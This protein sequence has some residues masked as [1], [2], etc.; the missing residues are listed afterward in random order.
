M[1]DETIDSLVLAARFDDQGLDAQARG[2][3]N[4]VANAV[5]QAQTTIPPLNI[6]T[7]RLVATLEAAGLD[8]NA[9][10]AGMRDEI[11][12]VAQEIAE[13][14]TAISEGARRMAAGFAAA[15]AQANP[16]ARGLA[17]V[18]AANAAIGPGFV[19]SNRSANLLR[20]GLA[21]LA[22]QATGASGALGQVAQAVAFAAGGA[23]G[24]IAAAAGIGVLALAYNQLTKSAREAAEAQQK[25]VDALRAAVSAGQD[26]LAANLAV[27]TKRARDLERRI[28]EARAQPPAPGFAG[29]TFFTAEITKMERELTE[30]QIVI[31]QGNDLF[32]IGEKAKQAAASGTTQKIKEATEAAKEFQNVA[33]QAG[34]GNLTQGAGGAAALAAGIPL[35]QQGA[36]QA[37]LLSGEGDAI[38]RVRE[39]TEA[40]NQALDEAIKDSERAFKADRPLKL[41]RG[42]DEVTDGLRDVARAAGSVGLIGDEA[43]RAIGDVIALGDALAKVVAS[44]STGNIFGAISAGIGVIGGLFGE[45]ARAEEHARI[46]A[47]NSERLAELTLAVRQAEFG[48]AGGVARASEIVGATF[49][50]DAAARARGSGIDPTDA[51]RKA[52][53]QTGLSLTEFDKLVRDTTGIQVLDDEGELVAKAFRQA[54][55]AIEAYTEAITHFGTTIGELE[56]QERARD[57]LGLSGRSSDPAIAAIERARDVIL[58]GVELSPEEEARVSAMDL[59]TPEGREAFKEWERDLFRRAEAGQLTPEQLGAYGS[60]TELVGALGSAAE[61]INAFDDA[62]SEATKSMSNMPD[63]FKLASAEWEARA[64]DTRGAGPGTPEMGPWPWQ[65]EPWSLPLPIPAP[66]GS[67]GASLPLPDRGGEPRITLNGP[68]SLTVSVPGANRSLGDIARAVVDELEHAGISNF[69]LAP[70]P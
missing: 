62:V 35:V 26:V 9:F 68:F 37:D 58:K 15:S 12:I 14:E 19:V 28:E 32:L 51:L 30:L 60:V 40:W 50:I 43:A 22:V 70:P 56:A 59:S 45:S 65:P 67:D 3:L 20:G 64:V 24:A 31:G 11:A 66:R 69:G 52:L 48:G 36:R 21:Q 46:V 8:V 5:K 54:R 41:A 18:A 16:W 63:T 27:A 7:K 34:G 44:A 10:F 29:S 2:A 13:S 61:G 55:E 17:N 33:R 25:S 4:V 57:E 47:Q 53:A 39:E 1:A 42:I 49:A 6:D 23:T 38:Q